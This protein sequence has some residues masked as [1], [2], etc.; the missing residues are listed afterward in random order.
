MQLH[1]ARYWSEI[2]KNLMTYMSPAVGFY[3]LPALGCSAAEVGIW[4]QMKDVILPA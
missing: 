1:E 2:Y 4:V 3:I